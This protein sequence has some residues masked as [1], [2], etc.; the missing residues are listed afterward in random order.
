MHLY[1]AGLY[2]SNFDLAGRVFSLLTDE[3]KA[4]RVRNENFLESYH[5]IHKETAVKRIRRDGIKVFLDSG[6]YSA[7]T[8]GVT[9]DLPKFCDYIHRNQDII[10]M[11]AALD[12]IDFKNP[13][14]AAKGSFWNLLEME[15]RG[16]KGIVP[17]YH[18]GEPEEALQYYVE[19]YPYISIGGLVGASAKMLMQW[20]DRIF[21]RYLTHA[22]GS[23]R[24][25][26]HLFGVTS[27][28]LML[29][30]NATSVDSS[31]WVQWSAMGMILLPRSGRQMNVSSKSTFKKM[32][33]Q[34]LDNLRPLERDAVEA[35]IR[36][37]GADPQRIRDLYYARWAFNCWAFPEYLRMRMGD[38]ATHFNIHEQVLF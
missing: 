1:N 29:R 34:H 22:D 36:A 31:T 8:Q 26:V 20:L 14:Q 37:C 13:L 15:K 9:I 24:T 28:P 16:V 23:L 27:L 18:F 17:T 11:V 25:Q 33:G 5:Y 7:L 32:Q 4:L 3:E 38:K 12:V 10:K 2:S 19:R 21:D 35:E 30:Y 6:A